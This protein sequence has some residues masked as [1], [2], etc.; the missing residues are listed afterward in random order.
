MQ[1]LAAALMMMVVVVFGLKLAVTVLIAVLAGRTFWNRDWLGGPFLIPV[2]Q[3][4]LLTAW[5]IVICAAVGCVNVHFIL[6]PAV[7]WLISV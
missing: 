7:Q 5:A 4:R 1:I 2:W 3:T 6:Y